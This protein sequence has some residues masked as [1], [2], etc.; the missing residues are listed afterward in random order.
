DWANESNSDRVLKLK[1][2]K[3]THYVIYKESLEAYS[4]NTDEPIRSSFNISIQLAV[5]IINL[6]PINILCSIDNTEKVDLKSGELYHAT[7]GNKQSSLVF[8]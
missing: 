8:T 2:G 3:E 5:H 6:L 1:D 4:E 7:T